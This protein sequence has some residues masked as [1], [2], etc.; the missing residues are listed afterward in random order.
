MTRT[1]DWQAPGPVAWAFYHS[2]AFVSGIMGP[3]GSGKTTACIVKAMSISARQ[4]KN[5]E[6]KR[7]SRG[8]IIRN[9]YPELR[10]TTIKS[11][12]EWVPEDLGKW[13]SEGPPTH[14]VYGPDGLDAEVIFL[15]LDR[16]EDVRKLLSLELTWAYVNEA[17]EIPLAIID[18]LTGRVGRFPPVR[19]GG[20][21]SP[22]VLMDTNPPD[23]DHW[24]YL[25]AERDTSTPRGA[26]M[27]Q[28]MHDAEGT[29]RG[30]GLLREDQHLFRFFRQPGGHDPKAENMVNLRPGYYDFL[31]AGKGPD[32]VKVYV[33]AEYGFVSDGKP[34]HGDYVDTLHCKAFELVKELPIYVGLDFGLT[35]A[36]TIGQRDVWG[37]WKIRHE[38][39][40]DDMG[41]ERFGREL[42][43]FMRERFNGWQIAAITGDPA[44]NARDAREETVFEVLKGSGIEARPASTNDFTARVDTVN[45]NLRRLVGGEP[46]LVIHPDC[47]VLR[48]GMAG[49]YCLRRLQIV[50]HE[51]FRDVPDKN[52]FSHVV[53]SLHYL[54]L[55]A[56]EGKAL[57]TVTHTGPPLPTVA[58]LDYPVFS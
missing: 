47:R 2:D 28:T 41:A 15:A 9:T 6:G 21:V 49:G 33:N 51:M 38:L 46:G 5:K 10:T 11:W 56:G 40:T 27:V 25:L 45:V 1:V 7:R 30:K 14:Y 13:Q 48:K 37:R 12:H 16:P 35:P 44:G 20:C 52:P 58:D 32:F 3:F 36:A 26:S 34:V 29:L 19:D 55:G 23:S 17:R 24:W 8:A 50:G 43:K 31:A 39:V 42:S 4:P 57:V 22:Q 53:E 54:L 18:G